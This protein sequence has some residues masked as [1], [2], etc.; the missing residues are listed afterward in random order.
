M[1]RIL[2][3]RLDSTSRHY[4]GS[5][6]LKL[7]KVA[8]EYVQSGLNTLAYYT[9]DFDAAN[10]LVSLYAQGDE[11]QFKDRCQPKN[12]IH[13]LTSTEIT[14][15]A[16]FIAQILAGGQTAR[17]VEPR[18]AEDERG[19]DLMNELLKWNDDQ[20]MTFAQ[21]HL[22]V[23][24]ALTFNR[25]VMYE[26]WQP[27]YETA[28]EE[29]EEDDITA[30]QIPLMRKD[31]RPRITQSGEP[32]TGFPKIKRT[33]RVKKRLPSDQQPGFT[34][35][36]VVSPYDFICDP[37]FP[38]LRFQE[39]RFAGHRVSI[40]WTELE[41]RSK[42]P[43]EDYDYVL[44][45][46]VEK[47]KTKK[48][49]TKIPGM[50]GAQGGLN[51]K[52]RSYY[53]RQKRGTQALGTGQDKITK[54][55]GGVVE[56][57]ALMI[58][59]SPKTYGIYDDEEAEKIELLIA[60]ENDLLS[61]NI[62]PNRHGEYPYAIG[63]GR[64]HAHQQFTPGV[65]LANKPVQDRVDYL[66]GRHAESLARTSG[67]IFVGDPT[68]IDLE[69]FT[70]PKK[71]GLI[72][73]VTEAGISS[74]K[75]LDAF[76]KQ[77]PVIDT[78]AGFGQE[79]E[80]WTKVSEDH[81]GAHAAVQGQMGEEDTTATEFVG[82]QQM[83][84]GRISTM[85]RLLSVTALT[86]QTRRIACN[87]SDFFPDEMVVRIAGESDAFDP[88]QPPAK[89]E[90]IRR[91]DIQCQYDFIPSDGALP[92]TDARKTAAL[93]RA[94]EAWSSNPAFANVFNPVIPGAIDPQKL[95]YKLLKA[96]GFPIGG[97]V[98]TREQAIKN[99]MALQ[100]ASGAGVMP[101][102]Q[103]QASN[104]TPMPPPTDLNGMPSAGQLPPLPS[105]APPQA[106]P[107]QV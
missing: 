94:V 41:R 47:L 107:A 91:D 69:A 75:P 97:L 26:R 80:Y 7:A 88:D 46:T 60:G 29:V 15:L 70:D 61:V 82:T 50:G 18:G 104:I 57:F 72:I 19:A 79:M 78:T 43:P 77:I 103:E 71:D 92:G 13:P 3:A 31:G 44:P 9:A 42:L 24:D 2:A 105:A 33:R 89:Y 63:E 98:V 106:N 53:E 49:N 56:C 87:F 12:F 74:G 16:T 83:A 1:N 40:A 51:N 48:R 27:I 21:M 100:L 65:A 39:G 55:D 54:E 73:Q 6:F 58:T 93:S 34:K 81:T 90:K 5:L 84:T 37:E 25:G 76:F 99:L 10:D 68:M 17:K 96:T 35:I 14:T 85:A 4:D 28:L 67:N 59:A 22:W 20:Q 45:A 32:I 86:P 23:Q 11:E 38:I 102:G 36:D 8:K 62:Q 101:T 64:P 66:N 30:D 95:F 52:S